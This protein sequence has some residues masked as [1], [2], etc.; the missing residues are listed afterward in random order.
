MHAPGHS[1]YN[2]VERRILPHC[3]MTCQA[4]FY[5]MTIS[6]LNA[7]RK[8]IDEALEKANLKKA[9]ETLVGVWGETVIDGYSV[10]AV[11]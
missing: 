6:H 10:H 1:V 3:R 8:T 9:R 7:S 4:L 5:H 11:Y 2:A